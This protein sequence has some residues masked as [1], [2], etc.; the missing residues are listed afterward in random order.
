MSSQPAVI[1][2][3]PLRA[4]DRDSGQL[5]LLG[6]GCDTKGRQLSLE[7][8]QVR[9]FKSVVS[10]ARAELRSVGMDVCSAG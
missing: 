7:V 8:R 9:D 6:F 1:L 3:D 10:G 5:A 4:N 2:L